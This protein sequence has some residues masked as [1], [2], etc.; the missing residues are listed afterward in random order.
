MNT[1]CDRPD[2]REN[3]VDPESNKENFIYLT[4]QLPRKATIFIS[5]LENIPGEVGDEMSFYQN[6]VAYL[7]TSYA[8]LEC[9]AQ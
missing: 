9:L 2:E 7:S 1:Q 8:W 5:M 4:L 3:S 6:L